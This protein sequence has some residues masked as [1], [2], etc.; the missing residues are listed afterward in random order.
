VDAIFRGGAANEDLRNILNSGYK[1]NGSVRRTVPGQDG[2]EVKSFR[3]FAPKALAGIENGALPET[4]ATRSISLNLKRKKDS[5]K[6]ERYLTR[7]VEADADALKAKIDAWV[8]HNMDHFVTFEAPIIDELDDRAFEIVE[9]FLA[10]AARCKGWTAKTRDAAKA[11]L[12]RETPMTEGAK[13][14]LAA[15]NLFTELNADRLTTAALSEATDLNGKALGVKLAP[16][17][18]KPTTIRFQGGKVAKGYHRRDFQDA[19]ERYLPQS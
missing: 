9:P 7:R 6:V 19:F 12:V 5:E 11:M 15:H 18:I 1:S 16:Y 14:L 13:I 10:I 8:R 17:G 4:L 2:G 3:T